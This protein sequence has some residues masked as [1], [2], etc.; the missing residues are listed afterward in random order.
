MLKCTECHADLPDNAQYC[1]QCGHK[2]IEDP[3][4]SPLVSND[5]NK[6]ETG[7][8]PG[9]VLAPGEQLLF[10][11]RPAWW[12]W[13]IAPFLW[14]IIGILITVASRFIPEFLPEN[15]PAQIQ[16]GVYWFGIAVITVA[17]ISAI[18]NALRR[19]YTIYAITNQRIL[20]QRGLVG[21]YYIDSPLQKVQTIYVEIPAM[22]RIFNFGTIGFGLVSGNW[23]MYWENVRKPKHIKRILNDIIIREKHQPII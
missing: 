1:Y 14:V 10:K 3:N 16:V 5:E 17:I 12:L 23:S 2:I 4:S 7:S 9:E 8:I 21:K 19:Y 18:I 15:W 13:L 22:G 20:L 6:D 11:T